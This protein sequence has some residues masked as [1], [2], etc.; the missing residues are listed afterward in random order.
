MLLIAKEVCEAIIDEFHQE[1]V[2]RPQT[3]DECRALSDGF[4]K[5][6]HFHHCIGAIDG[7]HIA[8]RAPKKSASVYHNYKGFFIILLALVDA[9]YRF[10]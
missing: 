9:D 8:I 6:T 7:K 3:L 5:M 1:V 2:C 10:I 4:S